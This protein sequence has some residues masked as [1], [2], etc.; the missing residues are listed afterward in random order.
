MKM[1]TNQETPKTITKPKQKKKLIKLGFESD[2]F[3]PKSE[4]IMTDKTPINN[5]D[6]IINSNEQRSTNYLKDFSDLLK[7]HLCQGYLIDAISL[8]ECTHNCKFLK[9][10][11]QQI[12]NHFFL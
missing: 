7:C 11:S 5:D 1:T 4:K 3:D 12:F 8:S 2:A 10:H 9:C 6:S